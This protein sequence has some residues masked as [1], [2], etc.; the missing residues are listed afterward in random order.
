[1]LAPCISQAVAC[2][3]HVTVFSARQHMLCYSPL[4]RYML[5]PV[6]DGPSVRLHICHTGGSVKNG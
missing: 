1:L 3:A 2:C 4:V 6:R 5:S